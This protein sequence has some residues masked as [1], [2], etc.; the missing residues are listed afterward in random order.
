MTSTSAYDRDGRVELWLFWTP[1]ISLVTV[2]I[3]IYNITDGYSARLT[4]FETDQDN[5][6]C[7]PAH[8]EEPHKT[9]YY[10]EAPY[11]DSAHSHIET[12]RYV[13]SCRAHEVSVHVND[14]IPSGST[15][16]TK[17]LMD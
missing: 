11:T 16:K 2:E 8:D 1:K 7:V 4:Q 13:V 3:R 12:F 5:G 10:F 17:A 9:K 14:N 6:T 15:A